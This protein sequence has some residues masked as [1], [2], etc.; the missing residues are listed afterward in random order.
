MNKYYDGTKLL[1]LMDING[2]KP[3][4][5]MST[6]NRS[7]GKTTYFNRMLVNRYKKYGEKFILLYRFN[8]ELTECADKFF[9]DIQRLFFPTD[10]MTE[11]RR[12]NNI[13]VE[14][15]LNEKKSRKTKKYILTTTILSYM[16]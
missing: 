9:K 13:F 16:I 12:A 2:D 14:L 11:K 15:F 8:Y 6:S 7:A 10:E 5:Y 3:E 1:S 4:I